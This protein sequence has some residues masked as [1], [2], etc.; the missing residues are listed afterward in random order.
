MTGLVILLLIATPIKRAH[1]QTFDLTLILLLTGPVSEGVQETV[2]LIRRGDNFITFGSLAVA[3]AGG[4]SAAAM[5]AYLPALG[6]TP[7]GVT[8]PVAVGY[9]V[10]ATALGCTMA[11]VS[12]LAGMGTQRVMG[13]DQPAGGLR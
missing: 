9:L 1:A 4:A 8:V 7:T 3:C 2:L 11:I 10:G 5:V 12:S 6:V 13:P